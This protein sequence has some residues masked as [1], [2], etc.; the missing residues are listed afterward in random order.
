MSFIP[1]EHLKP[2]MQLNLTP[3]IDFVFLMLAFFASLTITKVTLKDSGIS[4]VKVGP[5]ARENVIEEEK[6]E[7]LISISIDEAGKYKWLTEYHELALQDAAQIAKELSRQYEI[8]AL[9]QDKARTQ[10]LLQ[11]DRNAKWASIS[12]VI[13]AIR[14]QGFEIHPVY[15]PDFSTTDL[16]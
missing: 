13:F 9:P 3:M 4:L 8:G 12:E 2:K 7:R 10:V 1:E 11:I 14:E 16:K 6:I 15:Q 5:S